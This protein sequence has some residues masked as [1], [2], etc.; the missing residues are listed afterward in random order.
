MVDNMVMALIRTGIAAAAFGLMSATSFS[1]QPLPDTTQR[2]TGAV[3]STPGDGRLVM[4]MRNADGFIAPIAA[5]VRVCVTNFT[6]S[7]NSV[8]LYIWTTGN[9]WDAT[10]VTPLQQARNL[11]L[12][13]CVEIDQPAALIIQDSTTSGIA[14][15]YY[16]LLD[17]PPNVPL[18]GVDNRDSHKLKDRGNPVYI[19]STQHPLAT[20]DGPAPA[21]SGYFLKSCALKLDP[22]SANPDPSSGLHVHGVRICTGDKFVVTNETPPNID[23]PPGY[24]ELI[25][26]NSFLK[27]DPPQVYDYNW[28]P[29]TPNGCRDVIAGSSGIN[30]LLGNIYFMVGP[31]TAVP[32]WDA[33]KVQQII[34]QTQWIYWK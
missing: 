2:E 9:P 24:L 33:S 32:P 16:E 1:A 17:L 13:E 8:N 18:S 31:V 29:V 6:G 14:S 7:S 23:Y 22:Q 25:I 4:L 11:D 21:Q 10:P 20:C 26:N 30:S 28:N 34:V 12:G 19:G 5:R 15:G 3:W 27:I